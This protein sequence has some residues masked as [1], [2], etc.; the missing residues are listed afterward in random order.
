M[1]N[2]KNENSSNDVHA[3]YICTKL[4]HSFLFNLSQQQC[5]LNIRVNVTLRG[6]AGGITAAGGESQ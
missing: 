5:H 6:G 4:I 3:Q 2:P 1:C